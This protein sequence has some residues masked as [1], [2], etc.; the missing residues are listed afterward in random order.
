LGFNGPSPA[1]APPGSHHF[2]DDA[3]LD[4]VDRLEA[5]EV[6]GQNFRETIGRFVF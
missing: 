5:L 6:I 1:H 3:E 4:A 2:F